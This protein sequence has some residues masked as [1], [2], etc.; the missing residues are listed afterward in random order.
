TAPQPVSQKVFMRELRRAVGMPVG[1]PATES[2]V[3]FGA[4]WILKTDPELALYGRYLK[5]ERLEREGFRFQ[6]SSLREAMEDLIRN[7]R[8][9]DV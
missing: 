9:R 6:F 8:R 3:R 2:M 7:G 5:S 4:K 1:L